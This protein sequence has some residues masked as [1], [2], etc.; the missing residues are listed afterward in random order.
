MASKTYYIRHGKRGRIHWMSV[1]Q[2][3]GFLTT[4][5]R[6]HIDDIKSA[7]SDHGILPLGFVPDYIRGWLKDGQRICRH[8]YG[9]YLK[10]LPR[11]RRK[12]RRVQNRIYISPRASGDDGSKW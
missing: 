11:V 8:C 12:V 2:E 5:G 1:D 3:T 9:A 7:V 10:K 4:N 6:C